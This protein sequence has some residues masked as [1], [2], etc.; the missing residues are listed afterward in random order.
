M[1]MT[2]DG[3]HCQKG[4]DHVQKALESLEGVTSARVN[5][6]HR[7]AWVETEA[8]SAPD[9]ASALDDEGYQLVAEE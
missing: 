3:M 6:E 2:I 8:G 7:T 5:L 9:F 1:K 4:A